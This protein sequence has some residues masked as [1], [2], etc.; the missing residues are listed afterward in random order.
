M[1]LYLVRHT[2]VNLPSG[3]CYGQSDIGLADTF[4]DE[5]NTIIHRLQGLKFD[6]IYSSPLKRCVLLA[7]SLSNNQLEVFYDKR[8][9]ELNFGDWECKTWDEIEKTDYAKKWFEDFI[10][11]PCPRG[12]SYQD[13]LSR[14]NFFL[15]DLKK[16]KTVSNPLIICHSGTIRAF[17]SIIN[18]LEPKESFKLQLDFGQILG[19]ELN[20]EK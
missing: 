6:K 11:V 8:L 12:E 5:K 13:L 10:S 20:Q 16:D 17:Y 15:D 1:K 4:M 3:V 7:Q 19:I 2:K 9:M 14:V 18:H